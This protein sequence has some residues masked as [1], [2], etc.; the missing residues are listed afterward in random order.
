MALHAKSVGFAMGVS[1]MAL[2]AG[3]MAPALA[4]A[5]A[6][7]PTSSTNGW[8]VPV[9]DVVADPSIRYG[10]L[11]NGMRYAIKRNTTPKGTA[12]VRLNFQFG[13]IAESEDERGLAH[14]IE[15]MAFN[16]TT[17][18]AEG[19]MVRILERQGLAFGPDTN[20][21]TGFDST[22]Y[23]LDLPATDKARIDTALFLMREVASEVK[24]DP[25]AVQRERGVIEGERRARDSYQ[26]RYVADL[27]NF[28][29]PQ[30]PY[31]KRLPIGTVPV[32]T[33]AP[34]ARIAN[35]YHRYYRPELATLVIVGDID[36]V[37][38]ETQIKAKFSDWRGVGAAGTKLPRGSVDLTRAS[39]FGSFVDP[40][41]ANTVNLTLYRPFADPADT[42][43][44]RN[45]R[46][47]RA[48]AVAMFNR[49][50]ERLSTAA[51]SALLGGAM[52]V[53][54]VDDAAL[55]T[56][57]SVVAK[58]GEWKQAL[59]TAEQEVRRARLHGFTEAEFKV[60]MTNYATA[61][62][63]QAAQADTRRNEA[64]ATQIV[65]TIGEDKFIATPAFNLAQF[66]AFAPTLTVAQVNDEFRALWT[67]SAPVVFVA[68]K[69][70]VGTAQELATVFAKS[71]AVA[72]P[73]RADT[74]IQ[75]FA[76]DSFGTPGTVVSDQRIAAA[77][78]RTIRFANNVRLNIKKTDFEQDKIRFEVRMAGGQLALPL[79]KPGLALMMT[80]TSALGGTGKQSQDD[81]KQLMPGKVITMGAAV[82]S[83]AFVSAGV[84]TPT[85]LAL[86]LKVSA[87][88]LLDPGYRPEALN[89]WSNIVPLIDTQ[90]HAQPQ[91]IAQAQVPIILANDDLRFGLPDKATLAARNLAEAKAAYAPIVA[92]AP[93][94]IGIVGDVDEAA[95]IAA[96]AQSFG[97][98]PTRAAAAPAYT[99]ARAARFR[100]DL[101]PVT[102]THN[103]A[104]SQAMVI[105][106]WP[107]DDD[108]DPVRVAELGLLS[109]ALQIMLIDKVREELG[110]SYG[111]SV[112]SDLSDTFTHFG[113]LNASAVVAPDKI[114]E[115]RDAIDAAATQLRNAPVS[116]DLMVRARS[117]QLERADRALRENGAWTGVV[118]RAQSDPSRITRLLGLR[119]RISAITPA[120]LQALANKYLTKQHR[121]DVKI[122]AATAGTAAAA[123]K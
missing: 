72:T 100:T 77:G 6:A 106:A 111:A 56:S 116:P 19:E 33:T 85:D 122:V 123:A 79:D 115:V 10:Q 24:F 39:A 1:I 99:A 98:L 3:D 23:M 27:L 117:P 50:I 76:Y 114:D 104:A 112:Q 7:S 37:A 108:K 11:G 81:L 26:L 62:A 101:S 78:V 14:F 45:R 5:P 120:Q 30:T 35:L 94:D 118:T 89:Q 84:T 17:H 105:A 22:T 121:L 2:A 46:L 8:G 52:L 75:K 28:Q 21:Q 18:V 119:A 15:H 73:A 80:M 97:A 16:G 44:D 83:D 65:G 63:M 69:Q 61:F 48:V 9:T 87:A 36:P 93:I 109:S 47:V 66:T 43:A 86:Q 49:R 92:S 71:A 82:D 96:V 4:H 68:A 32:I 110:D 60:A 29:T 67:G 91:G 38:I 70:P 64:L 41:M 103:G 58:D 55:T 54:D 74:G 113:V 57:I 42:I 53:D 102:L 40:A 13:S 88:Y 90:V 31:G 25:A 59:S 12:S 20:A 34:A 107:T 95:A 51:D